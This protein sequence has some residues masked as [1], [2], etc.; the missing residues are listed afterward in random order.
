M[1]PSRLS[2]ILLFCTLMALATSL[3]A[4]VPQTV[5]YQGYLTDAG[6]VPVNS[7]VSI[8]FKLY[9]VPSG[10]SPLWSETQPSVAVSN[11][12][13]QATLGSV[14]P[15]ILPFDAQYYLGVTVGGDAEMTPRQPLS[16][17]PYALNSALPAS[18]TV[19]NPSSAFSV[20]NSGDG[21]AGRFYTTGS[22][23][24][25]LS[26][27][28]SASSG[29][30]SAFEAL[31]MGSGSAGY[32][33]SISADNLHSVIYATG[34]GGGSTLTATATGSGMAGSFTQ[35][36][37]GNGQLALYVSNQGNGGV[38][39]GTS[40]GAGSAAVADLS[41]N[42]VAGG[43][44]VLKASTNGTG[45]AGEFRISNAN[46]SSPA[47]YVNQ[48]GKGNALEVTTSG[49]DANAASFA[50][51]NTLSPFNALY[52][53]T[54]GSGAA[55]QGNA[56]GTG[57]AGFFSISNTSSSAA[58]LMAASGGTGPAGWFEIPAASSAARALFARTFGSGPA[59][60]TYTA[61]SGE[62]VYGHTNGTGRAAR[63]LINNA[64]NSN[65]ALAAT[66]NGTGRAGDFSVTNSSGT[67]QAL[68]VSQAGNNN[69]IEA[70]ISSVNGNAGSFGVSNAASNF[71][72]LYGY[73]QG[74]GAAIKGNNLGSGS[75]G[76]F[77][78][79]NAS[80]SS[81]ALTATTSGT[82]EAVRGTSTSGNAV[83]GVSTSG[84]GVYASS[85]SNYGLYSF[86]TNSVG[87]RGESNNDT[88]I[89]GISNKTAGVGVDGYGP[90]A[91]S[92]GVVGRGGSI[93][94][95]AYNTTSPNYSADLATTSYAAYF[96]GPVYATGTITQNS[97]RRLKTD[98]QPLNTSLDKVLRLRGVSYVMKDDVARERKIGVIAQ[99]LEE[100]Y[101]E[102]IATSEAGIKSVAYANLTAVL[103]E[104]VKGLKAEN[105]SLKA[106]LERLEKALIGR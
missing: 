54:I 45:K 35:A 52:A 64:T 1:N 103:I 18:T 93:G 73:H 79:N 41:V 25:Q 88:G 44:S 66:T 39:Y 19:S 40:F 21:S 47:L 61:G 63:F 75:G 51:N 87:I 12:I 49:V 98:I 3:F 14:T 55:I 10:G 82:G 42:N 17:V 60:E 20:T 102:L 43:Q 37:A 59:L 56:L 57:N 29:G 4:S 86:S 70:I 100:E 85:T 33:S 76:A 90:G 31:Q 8:V 77:E 95:R 36:N 99:E 92:I 105:D 46:S 28:F 94:V 13:Y 23:A 5:N 62:A 72:A 91:S 69:A 7:S 30:N 74:S 6:G 11:G 53:Y 38:I 65:A 24:Q 83:R 34:N 58:A 104:A 80:N 84:Y 15:L 26:T 81:T 2:A 68:Y 48:A 67:G 96:N 16:S 22:T 101:P 27:L 106:R 71:N 50:V 32:F 89:W 9:N 78:I 97:D